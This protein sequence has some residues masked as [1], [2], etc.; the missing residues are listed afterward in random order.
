M[1][2]LSQ[3]REAV[4]VMCAA[5]LSQRRSCELVSLSRTTKRYVK[6]EKHD[7][8]LRAKICD[9]AHARRRFG[10]RR[11][12]EK[13]RN[14]GTMVN[15]KKVYRIYTEENLKVRLRRRKR[16]AL[17]RGTPM[18]IPTGVN[19]RWSMD[20]VSDS[21]YSGRRF[22]TLNVVDDFSRECLAIETDFSL[23]S[24]RVTRVLDRLLWSRGKPAE[25][26]VD[27]G[28]EFRSKHTQ[29]W[30]KKNSI[31]LHY[32]DPGKPIQNAFVESFNGKFRDECLNDSWFVDIREAREVTERWRI[33]YNT[34]RP[35]SSLGYKTPVQFRQSH[36]PTAV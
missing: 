11:I 6:R 31:S 4:D 24:Q 10:Y 27:N 17:P 35:H 33:D 36:L 26:V 32:I 28:P 7:A 30:A 2:N 18:E 34:E 29:T 8:E 9:M 14:D 22:R 13:L 21:L 15:R 25:I 23:P 5:G 1:V 20:F 12:T 3:K 16:L 19:T